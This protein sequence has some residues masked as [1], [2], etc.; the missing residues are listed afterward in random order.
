MKKDKI[1]KEKTL[2]EKNNKQLWVFFAINLIAFLVMVFAFSFNTGDKDLKDIL[3]TKGTWLIVSPL[4]LFVLN[5]L[6]SAD[7]KATI[8]YWRLKHALPG[9]RAFSYYIARDNRININNLRK[10]HGD[11]PVSPAEQNSKWYAI[12]K[13]YSKDNVVNKSHQDFLLARDLCASSF[14]FLISLAIPTLIY[15]SH[16]LKYVYILVLTLQYLFLVITARNYGARFVCNVLA[17]ESLK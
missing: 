4:I 12:Y 10:L 8:V 9:C 6:A 15:S 2:K 1:S 13:T 5:G 7:Q 16:P 3:M 11:F 17:L 14:L